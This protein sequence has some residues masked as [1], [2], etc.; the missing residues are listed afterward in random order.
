MSSAR[1]SE[2]LKRILRSASF[3]LTL[4]YAVLFMA[5]AGALFGTV[6]VTATAAMQDDMA[7]VL[8]EEE[9]KGRKVLVLN[10]IDLAHVGPRFGDELELT[11]ELRKKIEGEDRASLVSALAHDAGAHAHGT[12]RR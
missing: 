1:P 8:A 6:Y 11:P 2:T 4:F 3:R 10:G 7:A 5:S 12:R 9:R